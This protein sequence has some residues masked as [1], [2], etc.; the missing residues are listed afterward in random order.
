MN[1]MEDAFEAGERNDL[2]RAS[3]ICILR[4]SV[5]EAECANLVALS[6]PMR[7]YLEA[8]ANGA[9]RSYLKTELLPE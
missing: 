8:N 7:P 3:P 2:C 5:N 9:A 6:L 4:G 1:P